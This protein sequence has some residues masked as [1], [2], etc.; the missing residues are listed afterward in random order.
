MKTLPINP[1]PPGRCRCRVTHHRPPLSLA[2]RCVFGPTRMHL[3]IS[4]LFL[5]GVTLSAAGT[6]ALNLHAI[7]ATLSDMAR[8]AANYP[9]QFSSAAERKEVEMRLR[10]ASRTLDAAA[11]ARPGDADVLIRDAFANALGTNLDFTGCAARCSATYQHLLL[12]KPDSGAGN[13][14]YGAFL[15]STNHPRESIRYLRKAADLGVPEA[16]WALAIS[17]ITLKDS[18]DAIRELK[19]Y[20]RLV[21]DNDGGKKLLTALES[22]DVKFQ[23][24][25][26]KSPNPSPGATPTR[27][28]PATR[29]SSTGAPQR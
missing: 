15:G 29:S 19:S 14:Q 3:R 26:V 4:V 13:F 2:G 22:K 5:L 21:P 7:D 1:A 16:H 10:S 28:P 20:M 11:A 9:P 18:A 24:V 25:K 8:H 23:T 12:L 17:Y 27:R 6:P